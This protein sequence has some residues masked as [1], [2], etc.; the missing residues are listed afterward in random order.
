MSIACKELCGYDLR[1]PHLTCLLCRRRRWHYGKLDHRQF[2]WKDESKRLL[3]PN[4]CLTYVL[5]IDNNRRF[6][7]VKTRLLKT[8]L[9][10]A[11]F[12]AN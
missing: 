5:F 1:R 8:V 9:S 2:H 10:F 7:S 4:D 3:I 11:E 6:A 12:L